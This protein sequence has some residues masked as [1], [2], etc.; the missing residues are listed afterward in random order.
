MHNNRLK[1]RDVVAI[2]ICLVGITVFGGCDKEKGNGEEGDFYNL[3]Y[4]IGQWISPIVEN[5]TLE[6]VNASVFI[7][8]NLNAKQEYLYRIEDNVLITS[9][10]NSDF[11][12]S[13]PIRDVKNDIV[14]IE[15]IYGGVGFFDSSGTFKKE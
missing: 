8:K 6:F 5:D 1:L 12:Y 9:L 10:P 13:H 14:V 2:A 7:R 11:E 3:E 15:N 4:R